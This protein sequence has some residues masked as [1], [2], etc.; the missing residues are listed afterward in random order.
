MTIAT[1][2]QGSDKVGQTITWVDENDL[3][4]DLGGSTI[5]GTLKD[6]LT[7]TV[8]AID[9][10][11][12]VVGDGSAGQFTWAYGS[13][14]VGTPG[15]Y[16]AQFTAAYPDTKKNVSKAIEFYVYDAQEVTP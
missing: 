3:T 6:H 2:V 1:A 5:T 8:R 15:R 12:N 7:G 11:L 13:L 16:L 10:T 9:G 14:D 4:I